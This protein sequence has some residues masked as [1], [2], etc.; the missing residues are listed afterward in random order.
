LPLTTRQL[1]RVVRDTAEAIEIK[2]RVSP[3]VLRHSF[4]SHLLEHGTDIRVMQVLLGHSKLETAAI[5]T[6]VATKVLRE[7]TSPLLSLAFAGPHQISSPISPLQALRCTLGGNEIPIVPAD[8]LLHSR[9][10]IP[11]RLSD[12]DPG[13]RG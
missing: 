6:T 3:H 13:A 7:V 5:Y 1:Y 9:G 12:A 4:A 11:W 2:K 10:F 8:R